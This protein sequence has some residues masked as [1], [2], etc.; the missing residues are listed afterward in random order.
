MRSV[1][2]TIKTAP[3]KKI[4]AG[5]KHWEMR[6]TSPSLTPPF[7]VL[8]CESGSHGIIKAAFI[9]DKVVKK[10]PADAM[11]EIAESCVSLETATQYSNESP[12]HFWHISDM[13]DYGDNSPYRIYDFGVSRAP[14]SWQYIQDKQ[15]GSGHG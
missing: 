8:C 13:E 12:L 5:Q 10:L 9:C 14:Q 4:R 7:R 2:A 15:E 1:I 11:T 3:L 6:K